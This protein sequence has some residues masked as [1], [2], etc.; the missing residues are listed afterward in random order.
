MMF[1]FHR[2]VGRGFV[3]MHNFP[4]KDHLC[5]IKLCLIYCLSL[6]LEAYCLSINDDNLILE[7]LITLNL[8]CC[9]MM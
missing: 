1:C 3:V 8:I 9:L 4:N 6:K 7:G 2:F 5:L